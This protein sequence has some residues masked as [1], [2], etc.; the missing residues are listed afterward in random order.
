MLLLAL[1]RLLYLQWWGNCLF[2]PIYYYT[3]SVCLCLTKKPIDGKKCG[4]WMW[5]KGKRK[6][7]NWFRGCCCGCC[8]QLAASQTQFSVCLD[9][10]THC[11]CHCRMQVCIA[12]GALVCVCSFQWG[13][14]QFHYQ[15]WNIRKWFTMNSVFGGSF[16]SEHSMWARK[17]C[18]HSHS[19]TIQKHL[20]CV[21]KLK[22]FRFQ[23]TVYYTSSCRQSFT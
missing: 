12:V 21:D 11:H 2:E 14:S 20:S 1:P 5:Q 3:L 10:H 22:S 23:W 17:T 7:W 9:E 6:K 19:R 16:D 18:Q 15:N 8:W 13:R 4:K